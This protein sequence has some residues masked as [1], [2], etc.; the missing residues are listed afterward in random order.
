MI[1][2]VPDQG[3]KLRG[4][5]FVGCFFDEAMQGADL[6]KRPRQT[7]P[8]AQ[9]QHGGAA[10]RAQKRST[11][12]GAHDSTVLL[13]HRSGA[14]GPSGGVPSG[15]VPSAQARAVS[16]SASSRLHARSACASWYTAESGGHQP[17]SVPA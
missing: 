3:R 14:A 2:T 6:G 5:P 12:H 7:R 4:D 8:A 16:N 1:E 11:V 9:A 17:C 13:R 15:A 10:G